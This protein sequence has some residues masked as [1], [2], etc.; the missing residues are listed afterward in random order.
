M[1]FPKAIM[2]RSELQE[3]GFPE[4]LLD[5][6]FADPTQKFAFRQQPLRQNSAILFDTSGFGKWLA[7]QVE[8]S[9]AVRS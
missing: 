4:R 8:I 9:K 7:K 3:M 1:E 6:A 5:R 2:R